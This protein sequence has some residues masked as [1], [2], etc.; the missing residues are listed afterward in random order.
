MHSIWNDDAQQRDVCLNF[1]L[2]CHA[3]CV[4]VQ[5]CHPDGEVCPCKGRQLKQPGAAFLSCKSII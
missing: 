5:L 3:Q 2:W 4:Y 1:F